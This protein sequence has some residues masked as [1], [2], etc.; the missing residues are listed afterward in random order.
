MDRLTSIYLVFMI[1]VLSQ[2]VGVVT[3]WCEQVMFL[4]S[5]LALYDKQLETDIIYA[6]H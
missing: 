4:V 1:V 6:S 5:N 2:K 3:L